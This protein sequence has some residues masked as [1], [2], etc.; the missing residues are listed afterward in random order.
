MQHVPQI[1]LALETRMNGWDRGA[2]LNQHEVGRELPASHVGSMKTLPVPGPAVELVEFRGD[3]TTDFPRSIADNVAQKYF[4]TGPV[5][6]PFAPEM[7]LKE[8]TVEVYINGELMERAGGT[9]VEEGA[10][11]SVAWLANKLAGFGLALQ[12]GDKV[13]TGSFT[14]F[15]PAR[16]GDRYEARFDPFGSVLIKIS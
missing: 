1:T 6:T 4:I 3:L 8:T 14:K 15:Y 16:P 9:A 12:A 7:D 2:V 13:M 10:E 11:G 5:T